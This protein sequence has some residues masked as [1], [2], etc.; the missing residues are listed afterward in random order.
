MTIISCPH[1]AEMEEGQKL[2]R[3]V[4]GHQKRQRGTRKA[5]VAGG[6]SLEAGKAAGS[7]GF[8]RFPTPLSSKTRALCRSGRRAKV[9]IGTSKWK[10]VRALERGPS[11]SRS[12][13]STWSRA[14]GTVLAQ[15]CSLNECMHAGNSSIL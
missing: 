5:L 10:N 2:K 3:Q 1:L 8:F 12:F 14:W 7:V 11:Q 15:E 9:V 4:E 6:L 13:L